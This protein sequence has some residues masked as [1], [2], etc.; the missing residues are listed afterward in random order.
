MKLKADFQ[1]QH[2]LNISISKQTYIHLPKRSFF[3][4]I[5]SFSLDAAASWLCIKKN[6]FNVRRRRRCRLRRCFSFF[7]LFIINEFIYILKWIDHCLRQNEFVLCFIFFFSYSSLLAVSSL[8]NRIPFFIASHRI[9]VLLYFSLSFNFYHGIT[10]ECAQPHFVFFSHESITNML[11]D[12]FYS[13]THHF[14]VS[15]SPSFQPVSPFFQFV[16]LNFTLIWRDAW[17][18]SLLTRFLCVCVSLSMVICAV[19]R[20]F[21]NQCA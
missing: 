2:N 12:R 15:F 17:T 19:E 16:D 11:A 1:D 20:V 21:F 13:V 6:F 18:D 8:L 5:P 9:V 10:F 14:R 3:R 4:A 7:F